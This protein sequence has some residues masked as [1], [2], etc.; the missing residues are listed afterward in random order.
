MISC[1]IFPISPTGSGPLS[2]KIS[3][4]RACKVV[5]DTYSITISQEKSLEKYFCPKKEIAISDLLEKSFQRSNQRIPN[6][7]VPTKGQG[8]ARR[9]FTNVIES[10]RL[11]SVAGVAKRRVD[12]F[13]TSWTEESS[14]KESRDSND[15][16]LWISACQE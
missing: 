10:S 2:F 16:V 12:G 15:I 4:E 1:N 5:S 11:V 9:I 6:Q 13:W 14:S 3:F 7:F 8:K